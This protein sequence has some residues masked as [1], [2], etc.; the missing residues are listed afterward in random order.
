MWWRGA[1]LAVVLGAA[2]AGCEG[3]PR[4]L[5]WT[6]AFNPDTLRE[7]TFARQKSLGVI[8]SEAQLTRRHDEIPAWDDMPAALVESRFGEE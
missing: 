7:E 1:A 5:R 6:V 2:A 3:D 8:P 4:S